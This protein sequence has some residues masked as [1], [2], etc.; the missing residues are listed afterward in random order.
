MP[1]ARDARHVR[2][3]AFPG[4]AGLEHRIGGLEKHCLKGCISYEPANHQ[5]MVRTRAAKV[6]AVADD[7]PR[8]EV[9]GAATCW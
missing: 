7:L 3:W 4:K 5:E 8:Q 9:M 2:G 1:Y 6:A